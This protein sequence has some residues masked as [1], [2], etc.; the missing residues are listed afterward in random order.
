[1]SSKIFEPLLTGRFMNAQ[2]M[3]EFEVFS[4]DNNRGPFQGASSCGQLIRNQQKL[5]KQFASKPLKLSFHYSVE[6]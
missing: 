5:V 3:V 1:M 2:S 4:W 6:K